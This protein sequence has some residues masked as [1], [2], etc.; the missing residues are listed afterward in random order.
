MSYVLSGT[1]VTP[2]GAN[3]PLS[4]ISP[5][6]CRYNAYTDDT[7]CS[8]IIYT[9]IYNDRYTICQTS[10]GQTAY[11]WTDRETC[12]VSNITGENVKLIDQSGSFDSMTGSQYCSGIFSSNAQVLMTTLSMPVGPDTDNAVLTVSATPTRHVT[13]TR[14]AVGSL[15]SVQT[16]SSGLMVTTTGSSTAVASNKTS[17]SGFIDARSTQTL[18]NALLLLALFW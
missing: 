7:N 4:R 5:S 18:I 17:N 12:L 8:C 13:T 3:A 16:G 6:S 11:Y 15:A 9:G 10:S 14:P 2:P 1:G